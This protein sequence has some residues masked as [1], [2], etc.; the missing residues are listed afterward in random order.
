MGTVGQKIFLED[1]LVVYEDYIVS[2]TEDYVTYLGGNAFRF[3]QGIDP[4]KC[5]IV[6]VYY[7]TSNLSLDNIRTKLS[8]TELNSESN[9]DVNGN[10][11][12]AYINMKPSLDLTNAHT[13]L[14]I[15]TKH[16]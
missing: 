1:L 14:D 7:N 5:K 4:T 8:H 16:I 13:L 10:A 6:V 15:K 11:S 3:K 2:N 12:Q 9:K